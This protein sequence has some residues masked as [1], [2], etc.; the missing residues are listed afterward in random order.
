MRCECRR[1]A[2]EPQNADRPETPSGAQIHPTLPRLPYLLLPVNCPIVAKFAL[3]CLSPT[4]SPCPISFANCQWWGC[5]GKVGREQNSEMSMGCTLQERHKLKHHLRITRF[6][7]TSA[8][9]HLLWLSPISSVK[10]D[11][12]P[13]GAVV[14]FVIFNGTLSLWSCKTQQKPSF[15]KLS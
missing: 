6:L 15:L 8:E 4:L 7:Y 12:M 10:M 11:H 14:L 13:D 2:A 9:C 1:G 5:W 3:V